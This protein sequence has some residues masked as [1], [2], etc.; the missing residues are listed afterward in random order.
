MK[1]LIEIVVTEKAINHLSFD[2]LKTFQLS[3]VTVEI[4]KLIE[5][6]SNE[7]IIIL[8]QLKDRVSS[9]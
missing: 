2:A 9:T 5:S 7:Q 1:E 3:D 8:Q 4:D 6:S